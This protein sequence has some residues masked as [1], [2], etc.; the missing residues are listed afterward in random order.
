MA[1]GV[2]I[3]GSQCL[4]YYVD[5]FCVQRFKIEI[6]LMINPG[7]YLCINGSIFKYNEVEKNSESLMLE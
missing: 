3:G 5:I 4:D 2:S 7:V 1:D 6:E